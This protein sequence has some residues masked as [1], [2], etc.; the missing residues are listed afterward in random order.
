MYEAKPLPRGCQCEDAVGQAP[1][2]YDH[3]LERLRP[4]SRVC[5]QNGPQAGQAEEYKPSQVEDDA[6]GAGGF[7]ESIERVLDGPDAR[8]IKVASE[9]QTQGAVRLLY[10]QDQGAG[11]D[12]RPPP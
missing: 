1:R 3:D 6:P 2:A 10:S 9:P 11:D 12:A 7:A 8:A 4:S 5:L